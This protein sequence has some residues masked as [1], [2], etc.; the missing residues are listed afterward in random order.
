VDVVFI[1]AA[2]GG[3]IVVIINMSMFFYGYGKLSQR[4]KDVD[5]RVERIENRMNNV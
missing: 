2:M 3:V 4:V 5:K 1:G